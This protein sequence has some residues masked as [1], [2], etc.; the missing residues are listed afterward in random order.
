MLCL[1]FF[2][3]RVAI[4]RKIA[5]TSRMK[6]L[7]GINKYRVTHTN[8][9]NND[10]YQDDYVTK[11]M[12][13]FGYWQAI[14]CFISSS[15]RFMVVWNIISIIFITPSTHFLCIKF[16]NTTDDDL[17]SLISDVNNSTCYTNCDEYSYRNDV[18]EETLI[19]QFG[20]VC[21]NLWLKSFTQTILM[22][23]LVI[24]VS[25]FGWISDR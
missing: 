23:G 22:F 13:S 4:Y 1:S 5:L 24:G 19:S 18:F 16:K 6:G 3:Y 21:E 10:K 7:S 12:G 25:T 20:L 15:I 14:M 11:C 8:N 9:E 17:E 2:R